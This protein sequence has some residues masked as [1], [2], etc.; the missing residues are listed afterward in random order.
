MGLAASQ[1]R[2]LS[3]TARR[4]N[5]EYEGQQINEQRTVLANQSANLYNQMLALSV[6]T[7]PNSQDFTKIDYK[8]EVPN[9]SNSAKISQINKI[10]GTTNQYTIYF[11]YTE[12]ELGYPACTSN[13]RSTPRRYLFYMARLQHNGTQWT[14]KDGENTIL[15]DDP[16]KIVDPTDFTNKT[17]I[18][19]ESGKSLWQYQYTKIV[20]E[21]STTIIEYTIGDSTGLNPAQY[22]DGYN[23]DDNVY[24]V[25][26]YK[27]KQE[28]LTEYN[29]TSPPDPDPHKD[30][31]EAL[32]KGEG[33]TLYY[34]NVGSESSPSYQY[35]KKSDLD[36]ASTPGAVET[37]CV[38]YYT[39]EIDKYVEDSYSPCYIERDKNNRMVSFTYM[40]D[41][42]AVTAEQTVDEDAYND[43]MNEYTYQTYLYEHEMSEINA[44]TSVVQQK[45][46]T[47]ELRL[48]QLD[49][50]ERA[51]K[52]EIEA[53][54]SLIKN[55]I[56]KSFNAFS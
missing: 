7:P 39:G 49:T 47:L 27:G 25:E 44:E 50:E 35:Y 18:E 43:A 48:K 4:V 40:G 41:D 51:V 13:Q 5:V 22:Y 3:L 29:P 9:V 11:N 8:F 19:I 34:V 46:K 52:Q 28:N 30:V 10:P 16:V 17:G 14:V 1:A 53:L 12:T 6:P 45:D 15:I 23:A 38:Y 56:E 42:Y 20:G 21:E 37:K 2:L 54:T 31:Y 33:D 36:K 24:S 55:D 26:T 32:C